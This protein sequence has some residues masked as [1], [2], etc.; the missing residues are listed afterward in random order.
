MNIKTKFTLSFAAIATLVAGMSIFIVSGIGKSSDGFTS[1]REMA[2]DSVL[3]SRVQANM[4]MVRM[5]VKDYLEGKSQKDIDEFNHYYDETTELINEAIKDIQAPSRAP[6]VKKIADDLIQYKK[7]FHNV[8]ALFKERD[9]I[10][11]NNLDVNGKNIE[12]LLT[13]VMESAQKDGDA[14]SALDVAKDIKTLLLARLYTSKFLLSN[15][16]SD[17]DRVYK[18]FSSLSANLVETRNGIENQQRRKQLEEAVELIEV[19]KNGV[20]KIN[21]VVRTRNDI[22][23][24]KLN[25]IGPDIAKLSEDVKLSIKKDQDTIGPM[26]A[27]QNSQIKGISVTVGVLITLFIVFLSVYMVSRALI[28]PLKLLEELTR[29]LSQGDGDLTKR[30][31]VNGK[32][33]IAVISNYVNLF[34]EKVQSTIASV[35]IT[36]HENASISHELSTTSLGVGTNVENS[37]GIVNETTKQAKMIQNKILT[38]ITHAQESKQDIIKANQNLETARD[39]I[40]T[41]TSKV[42]DT[43]Q[44]EA[45]LSHNMETLSKDAEEVKTVLVIISDI[46]DQTNLLAL[47]AAI[48]AARAGEHGRG[49]AVVADEVRKLAER[50]QKTLAEINATINVVVQSISDASVQMSANSEEIQQL[51]KIAQDVEDKI[52][53]T[54]ELVNTA[55]KASDKTVGDFEKT[56]K[57]V[58]MI[59]EKIDEINNISSSNARSVEEIAAASEHLNNLTNELNTKLET[60]R[61]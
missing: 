3:A 43:A 1:Y 23:D 30:L 4:L 7:E 39:D 14:K 16:D 20:S 28:R 46:A 38:S 59:V 26:V 53:S 33:E 5:N 36:S 41:L 42:Q 50:T 40:I 13:A 52:N 48:E 12:K 31:K 32:D 56:G 60:F 2:R 47:N 22:I 34:I 58:E 37:V 24:N 35:K 21:S 9:E 11:E 49:F 25:V 19:Y 8:I 27:S 44:T 29:D 51:A 6:D 55:V 15:S 54:V 10:V 45:E 57:D 61:T 17:I 18:E